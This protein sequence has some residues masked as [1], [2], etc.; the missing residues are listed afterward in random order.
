MFEE[1]IRKLFFYND[2]SFSRFYDNFVL[3]VL[4]ENLSITVSKIKGQKI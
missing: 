2:Q 3:Q 4:I 1:L